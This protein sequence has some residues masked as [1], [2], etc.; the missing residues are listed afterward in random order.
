[1]ATNQTAKS[2]T[3]AVTRVVKDARLKTIFLESGSNV[4]HTV[5][6]N[7]APGSR[8]H[9][10]WEHKKYIGCGGFG[11]VHLEKCYDIDVLWDD[12]NYEDEGNDG[13][14][15][16]R[17]GSLRA[18]KQLSKPRGQ[19]KLS[20]EFLRELHGLVSFTAP[21]VCLPTMP[22]LAFVTSTTVRAVQ[23]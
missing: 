12:S 17:I 7:A 5:P 9:E 20:G 6:N 18:V 4:R 15:P 2:K 21:K 23:Q 11:S 1:M 16:R 3:D 19:P 8:L 10:Y 13:G 14:T 22:S